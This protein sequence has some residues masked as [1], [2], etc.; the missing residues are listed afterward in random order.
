MNIDHNE[1]KNKELI[2]RQTI[3]SFLLNGS[4]DFFDKLRDSRKTKKLEKKK[5][6][7]LALGAE[8]MKIIFSN[9]L[10]SIISKILFF[11]PLDLIIIPS[12]DIYPVLFYL[13]IAGFVINFLVF[14]PLFGFIV[15]KKD[16]LFVSGDFD[17]AI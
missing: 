1:F 16:S 10:M 11:Y 8:T 9:S 17:C 13:M 4:P 12:V 7:L 14:H 3:V 15:L 5:N 6:C 2:V